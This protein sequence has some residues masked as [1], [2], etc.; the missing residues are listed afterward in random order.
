LQ[1]E[2]VHRL[3]LRAYFRYVQNVQKGMPVCVDGV[4]LGFVDAVT[5]RPEL[6][7]KPVEVV[8]KLRTPYEL[9]IPSKSI[10]QVAE[11]GILRPTVV[12]INTREAQGPPIANGGAID[13]LESRDD[14]TAHALGI[15]VK[16]LADQAKEGKSSGDAEKAKPSR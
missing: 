15:V 13:G 3:T 1:Y 7:E 11:P 14:Q 8:L 9:H 12:D 10:A 6:G 4:Q 5:V 2:S 16:A